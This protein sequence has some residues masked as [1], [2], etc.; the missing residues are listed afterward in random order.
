M[1][2][3]T[4][5]TKKVIPK[6]AKESILIS[7]FVGSPPLRLSDD[8]AQALVSSVDTKVVARVIG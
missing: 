8:F 3:A 6:V 1:L 5:A 2:I 4:M 7:R